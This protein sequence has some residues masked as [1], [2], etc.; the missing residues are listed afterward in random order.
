MIDW[1]WMR[2]PCQAAR[3]L[4]TPRIA[5]ISA[6]GNV[7]WESPRWLKSRGSHDA[8]MAVRPMGDCIEVS[9]SPAK[10]LQGHNVFGSD[11]V[12]GLSVFTIAG[13]CDPLGIEMTNSELD[14]VMAGDIELVQVDINYSFGTGTRA[15]ALAWI[16]AAELHGHLEHRGRGQL[17]K[18]STVTWGKGS[19]IWELKAYS[20]GQELEA[21]DHRLP[22]DLPHRAE[23]LEWA[24]DKIRP[25]LKLRAR[26]L[27]KLGLDHVRDW[28]PGTPRDIFVEHLGKLR[29][30][31]ELTMTDDATKTLPPGLQG[32][33][34]MW[35]AGTDLRDAFPR[36]TF[37][38]YRRKLLD[39]AG[40]DIAVAPVNERANVVPLVRTI[41][42]VP[43]EIP[44]WAHG[45]PIY[46]QAPARRAG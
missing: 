37:Y 20:K 44:S 32:A 22:A 36:R 46:W 40:V 11:D 30:S 5:A 17:T 10:F 3:L 6:D 12:H 4:K 25:E 43:A 45:T 29:L 21:P 15:N 24:N 19:R 33:L 1:L 23:L 31:G 16:R 27:R 41:E 2:V 42:A 28:K 26:Y 9:G 38:H 35:K 7:E 14:L 39:L 18:G 34:A 8:T 13:V